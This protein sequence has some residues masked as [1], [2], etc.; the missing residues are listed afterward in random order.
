MNSKHL[1]LTIRDPQISR[2]NV[3]FVASFFT[4]KSALETTLFTIFTTRSGASSSEVS[5]IW[6]GGD[7][8][9]DTMVPPH[10]RQGIADCKNVLSQSGMPDDNIHSKITQAR[11]GT[12]KD[13]IREGLSGYYDAIVFGKRTSSFF[14]DMVYGDKAHELLE[15][16]LAFPAWFCRDPEVGRRDVL[17]CVDGSQAGQ[18]VADHVGYMLADEPEHLIR[19]MHVDK[20]QGIDTDALFAETV[21]TLTDHGIEPRRIMTHRVHGQRVVQLILELAEQQQCAAIAVGSMGRSAGTGLTEWLI[22]PKC[23]RLLDN[24]EKSSLWIVP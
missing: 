18:R 11:A 13:I 22:T 5:T 7:S 6:E 16:N 9:S 10:I 15:S 3:K 19:L 20:G 21:K 24:T 1:L 12:V 23:K 2:Q 17:L 14:T 4:D 8:D